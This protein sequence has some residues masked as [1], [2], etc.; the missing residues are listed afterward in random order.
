MNRNV[1]AAVK[2]AEASL[3]K[4]QALLHRANGELYGLPELNKPI[5]EAIRRVDLVLE[6]MEAAK[7]PQ[8]PTRTVPDEDQQSF[9]EDA[10]GF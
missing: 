7:A 8:G 5:Q 9:I 1:R 6:R 3:Y 4:T 2:R 10:P